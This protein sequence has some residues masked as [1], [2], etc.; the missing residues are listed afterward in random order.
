MPPGRLLLAGFFVIG[1]TSTALAEWPAIGVAGFVD[2][3]MK[4]CRAT[5][6]PPAKAQAACAPA[7]RCTA[8]E[9]Q[10]SMTME[11]V[12]EAREARLKGKTTAKGEKL[13]AIA[14]LCTRRQLAR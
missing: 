2:S 6:S 1:S 5:P 11:D 3:C 13:K 9:A 12:S 10:K 8:D 4:S 7:C 14:E